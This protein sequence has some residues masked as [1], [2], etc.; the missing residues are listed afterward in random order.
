MLDLTLPD[1]EGLTTLLRMHNHAPAVPIVV[2]T[3]LDD[4]AL[5]VRAVREGAQDYLVKGQFTGQLLVR[6][7]RYA[8]E[9]KHAIEALQK[10]NETRRA[11]IETSPLAIYALDLEGNVKSWNSAAE[12]IFGYT[13]E[14]VLNK[15]LPI[16][17][18]GDERTFLNRLTEAAAG[19][20]L[21]GHE[22]RRY[23]SN[24]EP[25]EV[26]IWNA[27]LRNATGAVTGIVEAVADN[28]E[29]KRLEEQFRQA[30]KMEAVGRLAGGI[31][32]DFNN[33]LTVIAGYCQMLLNRIPPDD[34]MSEDMLQVLKAADRATVLTKQLL[35]FSR[36][37][38][39]QPKVVDLRML[40]GDMDHMLK[41]LVGEKIVLTTSADEDLGLVQVDP[42][43][44]QQV[45][46]N[47]VVNARD[48]MPNGGTVTIALKNA[49]VSAAFP[50]KH[51]RESMC[52]SK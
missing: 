11:V 39:F 4:E 35:A 10:S 37:Q 25:I 26:S 33:L 23:R 17:A 32:H 8:T 5:A 24:G 14:Q 31:A 22:E 30:Q 15:R 27:Q 36:R 45:I 43:H 2:L 50:H 40:L 13:E 9:R 18:P 42:G 28:S 38:V 48:A 34:P 19:N 1:A 7:M 46:V 21:V 6:A 12:R 47:L 16:V 52:C 41:R 44:L 49:D 29:R 3:G 51:I 20:L